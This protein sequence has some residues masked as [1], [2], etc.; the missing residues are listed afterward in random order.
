[1]NGYDET[2]RTIVH[3]AGHALVAWYSPSVISV[4]RMWLNDSGGKTAF[5]SILVTPA[6][7]WEKVAVGL[8]G[9]A[10]E[11]LCFGSVH[12]LSSRG[13]LLDARAVAV[14]F[15]RNGRPRLP[16]QQEPTVRGLDF[17]RIF[18]AAP[19]VDVVWL[20]NESFKRSTYLIREN[21]AGHD[22]LVNALR[23]DR[24][25]SAKQIASLFGPRFW[26]PKY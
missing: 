20:M 5:R 9:M 3:E 15:C 6:H 16:W 13:D 8:A 24:D 19:S 10:A 1:M 14:D 11:V 23:R 12:G 2:D 7:H 17:E 26:S 22:R 4:D 25:L 18:D 21:K